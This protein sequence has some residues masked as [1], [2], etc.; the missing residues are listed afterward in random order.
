MIFLWVLLIY[1]G[2]VLYIRIILT[3]N[4]KS[5]Y[6]TGVRSIYT[7]WMPLLARKLDELGLYKHKLGVGCRNG[8]DH[9]IKLVPTLSSP[10]VLNGPNG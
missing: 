5:L 10:I 2:L 6:R 9:H 4:V 8:H 7:S 1:L 3:S